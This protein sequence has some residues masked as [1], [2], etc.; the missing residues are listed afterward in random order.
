MTKWIS[1]SSRESIQAKLWIRRGT[2]PISTGSLTIRSVKNV[3]SLA[4]S[5]PIQ[6]HNHAIQRWLFLSQWNAIL[7]TG[8]LIL[9]GRMVFFCKKRELLCPV[10][11]TL[12]VTWLY[13]YLTY[14]YFYFIDLCVGASCC[15]FPLN[16]RFTCYVLDV[17]RRLLLPTDFLYRLVELNLAIWH[18]RLLQIL[19]C[20][21]HRCVETT[22]SHLWWFRKPRHIHRD[23]PTQVWKISIS[24]TWNVE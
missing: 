11:A 21:T 6:W 14:Q 10:C 4:L 12:L 20:Y 17:L 3:T 1:R 18:K 2:L 13:F 15:T 7:V 19:A 22:H 23:V 9:K 8:K 16:N 5:M 24:L